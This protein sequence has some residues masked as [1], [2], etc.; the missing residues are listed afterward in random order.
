MI[1]R[2]F[3]NMRLIFIALKERKSHNNT[4]VL[5]YMYFLQFFF[6][7][8]DEVQSIVVFFYWKNSIKLNYIL[9]STNKLLK[10]HICECLW[11]F[12]P[13]GF[14]ELLVSV[15]ID[16]CKCSQVCWKIV[17]CAVEKLIMM[18]YYTKLGKIDNWAWR[19]WN[20]EQIIFLVIDC[21]LVLS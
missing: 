17:L 12:L 18:I 5:S 1:S 20:I 8:K 9:L 16:L 13:R 11:S 2:L 6:K 4:K 7:N 14:R 10:W 21:F 19:L 3:K 15:Q